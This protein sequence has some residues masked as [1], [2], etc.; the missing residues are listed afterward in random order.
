MSRFSSRPIRFLAPLTACAVLVLPIL[1]QPQTPAAPAFEVASV[2]P[3]TQPYMQ[4]FA[5][6]S[7]GRIKWTTD[8]RYFIG[9]AYHLPLSRLAG[10]IPGSESIYEVIANTDA[11]ST[12]D[13]VRAMFQTLLAE[14]FKLAVHREA[15]ETDGYSL[16][17]GKGSLKI[18]EAKDGAA[19][20]AM[21]SWMGKDVAEA[22]LDGRVVSTLPSVGVV[23]VTGRRVTMTQLAG[24]LERSLGGFVTDDTGLTAKYYL[25]FKY[26][27]ENHP[28]VD[29]PTIFP[30]LQELGLKLERRKGP[31][32]VLVVDHV[33]TMPTGN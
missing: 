2:K 5:E 22:S 10:Q 12:D 1:A 31:V 8:L 3:S 27:Q 7:G 21:P 11:A 17:T 9:Y 23:T 13:Q 30:A 29:L 33:E 4:L 25:G 26:A 19:P 15:K 28:E 18:V 14:R 20:P 24:A 6:R 32:E 16:K